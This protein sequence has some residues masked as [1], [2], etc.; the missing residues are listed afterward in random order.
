MFLKTIHLYPTI[1]LVFSFIVGLIP[2]YRPQTKFWACVSHSV[3]ICMM[4]LPV[5]LHDP[6][7]GGS[8]CLA[9]CSFWG[10][11]SLGVSL[12]RV[13]LSRGVSVGGFCPGGLCL[14]EG[15]LCPVKAG[16]THP[17]GMLSC[18][19]GFIYINISG[20]SI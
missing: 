19:L 5:W 4:T 9:P 10:S 17:T 2:C 20:Q 13:S 11:P 14:G 15:G 12:S 1:F 16:G 8:L 6:W 7:E 18:E 3:Y